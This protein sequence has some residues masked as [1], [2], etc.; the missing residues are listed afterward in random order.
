M[1][2][3]TIFIFAFLFG[4]FLI[5]CN[6]T[7]DTESSNV[8]TNVITSDATSEEFTTTHA[9]IDPQ[10]TDDWFVVMN[11]EELCGYFDNTGQM[12]IPFSF[13]TADPFYEGVAK[14]GVN[15]DYGIINQYGEFV[16][17]AE[18]SIITY[19]G[20]NHLIMAIDD[21]HQARLFDNEGHVV[22]EISDVSIYNYLEYQDFFAIKSKTSS[23]FAIYSLSQ[24]RLTDYLYQRVGDYSEEKLLVWDF[25]YNAMFLDT[26]GE[27]VLNDGYTDGTGFVD[28]KANVKID[29][30]YHLIDTSGDDV[31]EL[32]SLSAFKFSDE[33]ISLY[34]VDD[35]YGLCDD[36][37]NVV[38]EAVFTPKF[39]FLPIT[40]NSVFIDST[41][42]D[43]IVFNE[44]GGILYRTSEYEILSAEGDYLLLSSKTDDE[45][46]VIDSEF[47]TIVSTT[48]E[49]LLMQT[50]NSGNVLIISYRTHYNS[51]LYTLYDIDG[52]VIISDIAAGYIPTLDYDQQIIVLGDLY[53]F[54]GTLIAELPGDMAYLI[55]DYIYI[56]DNDL[57]GIYDIEGNE[58][59]PPEF[60]SIY[61]RDLLIFIFG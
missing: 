3:T 32:T 5:A 26:S 50:D 1:K 29:G 30:V 56:I 57:Y 51:T 60:L 46:K 22:S 17:D 12:M 38:V 43:Q 61:Y 7:T 39:S 48:K 28:G 21:D 58:I 44:T 9:Y 55:G 18:Y 4:L 42:E 20:Y 10:E 27:V 2:K 47:N 11:D 41:N 37:G 23:L 25:S 8:T 45:M 15:G 54:S 24:G 33:G 14:V 16:L 31:F 6:K 40:L 53:D 19:T 35:K 36:L 49:E 34:R 13:A 52:R 59:L